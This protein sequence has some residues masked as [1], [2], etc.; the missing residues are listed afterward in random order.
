MKYKDNNFLKFQDRQRDGD[1]GY[2]RTWNSN[3]SDRQIRREQEH[4]LSLFYM[5]KLSNKIEKLW[6]NNLKTSDK[7]E[8]RKSYNNQID[9]LSHDKDYRL[10]LWYSY[11]IFESWGEWFD[12]NKDNFKP[13]KSSYRNDKLK[14]LGI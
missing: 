10:S 11:K 12:Y 1:V 4:R 9:Y 13:N 5:E 3:K 8:I 6:W 14:M 7:E 2:L